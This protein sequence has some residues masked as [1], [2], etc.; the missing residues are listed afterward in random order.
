METEV[1]VDS[2]SLWSLGFVK[3]NNIPL[4]SSGSI[5][6]E[7]TNCVAFFILSVFNIKDSLILPVNE[8]T[9]LIFENLEPSRVGRPDLHVLSLTRAL[10]IE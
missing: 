2:L 4:L 10:D 5:V 6:F 8:L 9:I 1:L 7:N 3:I